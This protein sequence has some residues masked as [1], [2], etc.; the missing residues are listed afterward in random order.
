[1]KTELDWL[2]KWSQ[3]SPNNIAI[4]DG[5]TGQEFSYKSF[6]E[7]SHKGAHILRE[8]FHIEKV[9][10]LLSLQLMS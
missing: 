9:T 10:V 1:M 2:K 5:E 3:Y 4:K 7:L 6:Y 8:K